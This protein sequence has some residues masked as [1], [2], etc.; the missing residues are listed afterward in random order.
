MRA[1][2]F[3]ED[4]VDESQDVFTVAIIILHS[5]VDDDLILFPIDIDDRR[6]DSLMTFVEEFDE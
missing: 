3:G 6:I 4:I 1:P 5:D 2:F